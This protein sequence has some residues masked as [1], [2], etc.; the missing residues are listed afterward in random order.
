M[1][2]LLDTEQ[3]AFAASLDALLSAA[4]TTAAVRAREAGD[5]APTRA[6][7]RRLGES[8]VFALAVPEAYRGTGLL[9]VE[10]ALSCVELGRHGVPG[11]L[12]ESFAASA[13]LGRLGGAA[14][15]RWL[16]P[17]ADGTAV[18]TLTAT[19]LSPYAADGDL[20]DVRLL[21]T[22]DQVRMSERGSVPP[23]GTDRT[24]L[25]SLDPARR[26][27]RPDGGELLAAGP[28]PA[29]A[30]EHALRIAALA[31]AALALGTGRRLL[32]GT[33]EYVNT[34]VQFGTPVGAF[35]AVKH[36]LADVLLHLEFAEPLL[37]GAAVALQSAA[38]SAGTDTAAAKAACG[39]AG[40]AAARAALQLHGA[41]GYT[42]EFDL[43]LWIRRA[44]V[45]RSAWGS[46]SACRLAV[47]A[48]TH[49]D[50]GGQEQ[51]APGSD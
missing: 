22:D 10:L 14:A 34:R 43:S 51:R 21:L 39:E 11:P 38:P 23:G 25:R 36:R 1:R 49:A 45:L 6:L 29:A 32:A 41:I 33:V 50:P 35:Q 28:G 44:R 31:T 15:A 46:P 9:P 2:F 48:G 8:G 12:A 24:S 17:A 20:A 40:Y 37:Y 47:L 16:P 26:L 5:P 42:D 4:D 13:L 3:R 27:S 30:A 7:W 19:R 18:L